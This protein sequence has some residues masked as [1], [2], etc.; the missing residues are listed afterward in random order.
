MSMRYTGKRRLKRPHG[1][2]LQ[3][4]IRERKASIA[5][6]NGEAVSINDFHLKEV[7]RKKLLSGEFPIYGSLAP[8]TP[9]DDPDYFQAA[10]DSGAIGNGKVSSGEVHIDPGVLQK[11]RSGEYEVCGD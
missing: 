3:T 7:I 6:S 1:K 4:S 2:P 10:Q 9:L 11:I 5:L 8:A